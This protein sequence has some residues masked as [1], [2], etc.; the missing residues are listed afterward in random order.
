LSEKAFNLND[1]SVLSRYPGSHEIIDKDKIEA[2][3]S[4]ESILNMVLML[5]QKD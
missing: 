5:I 4:A 3:Q 2:L 1:Y